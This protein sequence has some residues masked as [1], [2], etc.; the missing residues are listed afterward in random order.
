MDTP[1]IGLPRASHGT[2]VVGEGEREGGGLPGSECSNK[3]AAFSLPPLDPCGLFFLYVE[4]HEER[5]R[6]TRDRSWVTAGLLMTAHTAP[7]EQGDGS[8]PLP[9]SLS[10]DQTHHIFL[11]V[12]SASL[13]ALLRQTHALYQRTIP[14]NKLAAI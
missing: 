8:L 12:A 7:P 3:T 6:V 5:P 4:G 1:L 9:L 11:K 10:Q 2:Q 13:P 14:R